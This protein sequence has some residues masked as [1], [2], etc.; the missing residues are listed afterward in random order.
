L[1]LLEKGGEIFDLEYQVPFYLSKNKKFKIVVDFKYRTKKYDGPSTFYLV[2]GMHG[3]K[4][5]AS[6]SNSGRQDRA[7]TEITLWTNHWT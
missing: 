5:R 1:C 4:R 7:N 6:K 3:L 2:D